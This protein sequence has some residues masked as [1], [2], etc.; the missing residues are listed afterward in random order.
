MQKK[1]IVAAVAGALVAPALAYAQS[2]TVQLYG[3]AV[4]EYGYV[5]QGGNKEKLVMLQT[6]GGRAIGLKG[7]E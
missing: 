6:P 5:D 3:R 2:S 7:E 4:I 1:L